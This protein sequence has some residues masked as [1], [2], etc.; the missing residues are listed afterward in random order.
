M[1]KSFLEHPTGTPEELDAT[2]SDL[3]RIEN[4]PGVDLSPFL[5]GMSS[6]DFFGKFKVL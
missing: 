4:I 2:R 3:F 6:T 5:P 1:Y